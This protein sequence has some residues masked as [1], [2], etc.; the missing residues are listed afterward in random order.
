[1]I[2]EE[3]ILEPRMIGMTLCHGVKSRWIRM[4]AAMTATPN[5][6]W[7]VKELGTGLSEARQEGAQLY[8]H[9]GKLVESVPAGSDG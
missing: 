4:L 7:F 3:P 9:S 8:E 5:L 2:L 6:E 1:M